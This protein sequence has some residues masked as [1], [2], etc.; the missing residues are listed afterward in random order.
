M[1]SG[2]EGKEKG[3][4]NLI[5]HVDDDGVWHIHSLDT[6]QTALD[7]ALGVFLLVE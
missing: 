7:V 6:L 3:G 5:D 1:G 2:R 4:R